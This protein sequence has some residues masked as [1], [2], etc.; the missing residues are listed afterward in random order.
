MSATTKFV[1]A[2][3]QYGQWFV[4]VPFDAKEAAQAHIEKR[5]TSSVHNG[6]K[7][8]LKNKQIIPIELE[9]WEKSI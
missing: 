6:D 3:S 7:S 5:L 2:Y 4:T 9:E 8:H 1:V